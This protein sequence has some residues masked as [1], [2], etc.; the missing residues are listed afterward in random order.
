MRYI[1][2]FKQFYLFFLSLVILHNLQTLLL[3]KS[4]F[5][6]IKFLLRFC[7]DFFGFF[8]G[9]LLNERHHMLD[10]KQNIT[11][12][13]YITEKCIMYSLTLFFNINF[14]MLL[15]NSKQ[16]SETTR[17]LILLTCF[18]TSAS[19]RAILIY[20]LNSCSKTIK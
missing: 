13:I 8:I 14:R 5:L 10:L 12:Q 19:L 11:K 3:D 17:K 4:P 2:L 16:V 1:H 9:F 20:Q 15:L 6:Y 18:W 7:I